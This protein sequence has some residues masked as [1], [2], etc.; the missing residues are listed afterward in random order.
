LRAGDVWLPG[1]PRFKDFETYLLG[2]ACFA[3][4]Q[5]AQALSVA[6]EVDSGRYLQARLALLQKKQS[7]REMS[8][9]ARRLTA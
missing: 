3:T 6:I 1:S 8:Y 4:L 2:R 7:K 5:D 9:F